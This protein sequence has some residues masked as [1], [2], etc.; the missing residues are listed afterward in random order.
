VQQAPGPSLTESLAAA[1]ACCGLGCSG[2]QV[3]WRY[4]TDVGA[5]PV[6]RPAAKP[7]GLANASTSFVGRSGAVSKVADLLATYRLVT[8]TGPGGVGKTRLADEVLKQVSDRFADGAGIVE[9]AAVSEPAL[10]AATAAT[11]LDVRQAPGMSIADALAER[12]ALRQLLLVLDNCEHVL[13][14][15]AQ[16]CAAVLSSADD[17]RILVTSREPLGLPE[18][19]RYRLSPL[20]LPDR[21]P[22]GTAGQAE[23]VTLF[24]ERARQLDPDFVVDDDSG[25]KVARLVQRLDGMP[26]AIELAAARVEA[27]GLAQLLERLDGRFGLLV[28]A[29]RAAAARHRS[30]EAT[31]EWSY[32][33]LTRSE[34]CVFRRLSVFPGSFTLDAAE[35]VA[36]ADAGPAVLRLVDCSLLVPPRTGPDGRSRYLMLETLRS[37]G[38]TRLRGAE[39]EQQ[40]AAALCVHALDVAEHAAAQMAV[41]SGELPGGLWL[42]AEDAAV[43]QGLAWALDHEPPAAL[44]LAVALAPWWHV[45]GRWIQGSALLQRAVEQTGPD[46]SIWYSALLRL[47]Q[48]VYM[49]FDYDSALSRYSTVVAALRDGPASADL[50]EALLGRCAVLRNL[51]S[52]EQAA[53]DARAALE[54]AREI[55]YAAG[56]AMALVELSF[57]SCYADDG[58]EAAEWA[59]QAQRIDQEQMPGWTARKVELVL[60]WA[61]MV[62]GHLDGTLDLCAQ[63]LEH[64][65]AAGDVMDQSDALYIMADLARRTGRLADAGAYLRDTAKLAIYA[66]YR[67]R[68]IDILDDA[69]CWC[70]AAGQHAA[71]V[72]LWSAQRTQ[73]QAAGLADTPE[74]DRRREG[75][76]REALQVLDAGQVRAAEERGAAMTLAA[77]VEFAVMMTGQD[78][79]RPTAPPGTGKLSSREREL[80]TLVAQGRT[81]AQIAGELFI[82]LSTVRTHLDRI[83]DKSGYRRRADLTRLALEEGII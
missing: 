43:H 62:S 35:A 53:A 25:S 28:S 50:V 4:G 73:E 21:D 37:Y 27:L 76:L 54:L 59:R 45:R 70:V 41:R 20:G 69:G 1:F 52:L 67:V 46:A 12:L 3:T 23:A 82:S 7:R 26:L 36:G 79:L 77:A 24:T 39:E 19:A 38:M 42:D 40:A 55:S 17:V 31:V 16:L 6:T 83:R 8:I 72:T 68:L 56:E 34:Q 11:V 71:A 60:P 80:I 13:D 61:L 48:L 57:I 30:L 75:P 14:A 22:G 51:P 18:E 10:V 64:A 33:L 49:T 74:G 15:A 47:G 5:E 58:D 32:Q 2:R 29:N 66:G 78:T 65:R 63:L 44:R 9:L 81:D